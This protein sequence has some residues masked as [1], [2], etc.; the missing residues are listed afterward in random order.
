M[1]IQPR[2]EPIV[3]GSE[4]AAALR[5]KGAAAGVDALRRMLAAIM[6]RGVS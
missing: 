1:H 5:R 3:D 6:L 4:A 2:G